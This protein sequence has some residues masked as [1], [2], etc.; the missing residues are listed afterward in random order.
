MN[1]L[2]NTR[3]GTI[4]ILSRTTPYVGNDVSFAFG[5]NIQLKNGDYLKIS[6]Q[7]L[8]VR[9]LIYTPAF[10]DKKVEYT[11]L[12]SCLFEQARE[13]NQ[14]FFK[15]GNENFE[16]T[17]HSSRRSTNVYSFDKCMEGIFGPN[18]ERDF[19]TASDVPDE[20]I[21]TCLQINGIFYSL[22]PDAKRIHLN[23]EGVCPLDYESLKLKYC[24]KADQINEGVRNSIIGGNCETDDKLKITYGNSI[25]KNVDI[26]R[27]ETG[28]T[29]NIAVPGNP[30]P[31][32]EILLDKNHL[33]LTHENGLNYENYIYP[34]IFYH[35]VPFD[36]SIVIDETRVYAQWQPYGMLQIDLPFETTCNNTI[37]SPSRARKDISET[38]S[39]VVSKEI[40]N[41]SIPSE[42]HT[43]ATV[44]LDFIINRMGWDSD[45]GWDTILGICCEPSWAEAPIA[46]KQLGN[47]KSWS[48]EIPKGKEF[49]FVLFCPGNNQIVKWENLSGNRRCDDTSL[50]LNSGDVTFS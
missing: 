43:H 3:T 12:P 34:P 19:Y 25:W 24:E 30:R 35:G 40:N 10:P 8:V 47:G 14:I 45:I 20:Y 16:L 9:V 23:Q 26:R 28:F 6:P 18:H 50:C 11:D 27:D 37:T 22:S 1:S 4:S 2:Q 15:N 42:N 41:I 21:N 17:L 44:E 31:Y 39:S 33:Y 32:L 49:K 13:G 5:R 48:G 38:K 29:L 46:F 7:D 36:P